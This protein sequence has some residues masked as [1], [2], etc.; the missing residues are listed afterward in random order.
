VTYFTVAVI[1]HRTTSHPAR[2]T[3]SGSF[4]V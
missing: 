1:F 2:R 4:T 3:Y